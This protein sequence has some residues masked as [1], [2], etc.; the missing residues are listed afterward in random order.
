MEMN[1]SSTRSKKSIQ[2]Q[3]ADQ[4]RTCSI[5]AYNTGNDT[6]AINK[7][8][9]VENIDRLRTIGSNLRPLRKYFIKKFNRKNKDNTKLLGVKPALVYLFYKIIVMLVHHSM[10]KINW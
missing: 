5:L 3:V 7:I 2:E 10:G 1:A 9:C 8:N 6:C 4:L